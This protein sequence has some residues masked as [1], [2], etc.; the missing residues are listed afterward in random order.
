MNVVV[1]NTARLASLPATAAS[2]AS[3]ALIVGL[4][5]ACGGDDPPPAAHAG[6]SCSQPSQCYTTLDGATLRGEVQCLNRV[7]GGYCTHLC[8]TDA[9]CCAVPGECPGGKKQVCAPFEST[10]QMMCFLS[11]EADEVSAS[12]VADGEFCQR[13]AHPAFGCRSSGGGKDN[14]KVCVP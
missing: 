4:V 12:G 7:E 13:F 3:V 5:V 14:R 6:Q 11:C 10:G 9:D 2:V 1:R 8:A